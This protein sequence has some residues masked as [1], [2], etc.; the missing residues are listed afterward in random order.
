M[1]EHLREGGGNQNDFI[2][3]TACFDVEQLRD[4]AQLGALRQTDL[5]T[6]NRRSACTRVNYYHMALRASSTPLTSASSH[7]MLIHYLYLQSHTN[8]VD[9]ELVGQNVTRVNDLFEKHR[10]NTNAMQF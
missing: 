8:S 4:A 3:V 6:V 9:E 5:G 7:I 10:S 2:S 1:R